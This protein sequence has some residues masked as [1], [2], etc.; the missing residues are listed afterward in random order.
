MILYG[1]GEE[2]I[3]FSYVTRS[4]RQY[5]YAKPFEGLITASERRRR[6][7]RSQ[8]QK[9]YYGKFYAPAPCP[10]CGGA[11]LRPESLS[12]RIGDL[13]IAQVSA[14]DVAA[15]MQFFERLD[16]GVTGG[17]VAAELLKEVKARLSFMHEVGVGYLT[18]D[19]PAPTLS[20][21][22]AQ[23]IRLAT[24]IG[25][26]L[27]GVLYI[28]DEPSI[29]LHLRD[30][31]R[32][33]ETLI[34]LRDLGNTLIVVEHDPT[35]I[36]RADYVVEFGPGAGVHGGHVTYAGDVAGLK[37]SK[38]ALTGRYLSGELGVPTPRRRRKGTGNALEVQR[39]TA[40]NLKDVNVRFPLG[41]LI[42]VT[43]VSGS[44]KSTLVHD[45]LYLALR[46][47]LHNATDRPGPHHAIGGIGH[48]DKVVDI[49]QDPI[50]RTPR[51]NPATYA[52]VFAHIRELFATTPEARVRG[53]KPGRFSFNVKG[54]RCEACQGDG[55]VKIEMQFLSDVYVPCEECRGARYDRE[56]LQVEY[57]GKNIAEVLAL[58]VAEALEHFSA[59]P[60]LE[61]ILRTLKDVGLD[62]IALGQP[63]TT[64]S[65][66]EAQR[67]KLARELS[68]VETG[69]TLYILDEPTTGLHFADTERLLEVLNRLV[70]AGNTVIVI[71]HNLDVIRMADWVI[72]LG[73][74]GGAEGGYVVAAG[75]PEQVAKTA[76]SHTAEFL[77]RAL[78]DAP[79]ER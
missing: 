14:L 74:E 50:G 15:C 22:E 44:G 47:K 64:L 54:G 23:R 25:S 49:D 41:C 37:A 62:Y 69:N 3:E 48:I 19:R 55:V 11:R 70:E 20:G 28:L 43:G 75:T 63:A 45:V 1:S 52:G 77:A 24:Q 35:T 61:R 53:Y 9:Q 76:G 58:T 71:E 59:V 2:K 65:G 27:A 18:L 38:Q 67:L 32:L 40:H 51:S 72:D 5:A 36:E 34:E 42:G 17:V 13:T 6:E 57:K 68:K 78:R 12:V 56:T 7:T 21:G 60:S 31:E 8:R 10:A 73:P 30:H 33:L 29:G 16:L 39:A 66:G 4:G 46:R 26:G 79:K